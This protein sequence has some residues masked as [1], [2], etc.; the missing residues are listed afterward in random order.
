LESGPVEAISIAIISIYSIFV[1]FMLTYAEFGLDKYIE[2]SLLFE[3][4]GIFLVFFLVEI[5]LKTFASNM[6]YLNEAFNMFDA[7]IVGASMVLNQ[8]EINVKG[9]SVLRLVR[10]VVIILRKITGNTSK[11]RHQN[12]FNNPV[13]A[14]I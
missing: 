4:D 12:K 1:L 9:L 5:F 2:E 10:V 13:E 14:V 11:L 7:T 8:L 3:I 6:M